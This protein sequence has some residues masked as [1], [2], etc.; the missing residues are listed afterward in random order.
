[1][2][3]SQGFH[4][5]LQASLLCCHLDLSSRNQPRPDYIACA[6]IVSRGRVV[7]C[8]AVAQRRIRETRS[9]TRRTVVIAGHR[10]ELQSGAITRVM[11]K[12]LP[13][14]LNEHYVVIGGRRYPPKQVIAAVT[15]L[16]RADF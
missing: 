16:D 13:E 6:I 2:E 10:F 1:A 7:A 3:A 11:K 9:G 5:G 15:G 4:R 14:P 12:T 8:E